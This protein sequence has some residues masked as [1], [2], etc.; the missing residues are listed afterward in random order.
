MKG[1]SEGQKGQ[2]TTHAEKAHKGLKG[3]I[4]EVSD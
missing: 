3:L 4:E 2:W 1:A